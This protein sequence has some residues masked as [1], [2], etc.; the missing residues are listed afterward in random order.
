MV[1]RSAPLD[2]DLVL[3]GAPELVV[4]LSAVTAGATGSSR[5]CAKL[6]Q[7]VRRC[8]YRG[9]YGL[10]TEHALSRFA[11]QTRWVIAC[12][13]GIACVS[14]LQRRIGQSFGPQLVSPHHMLST[15]ISHLELPVWHG[16]GITVA[17]DDPNAPKPHRSLRLRKG[18][19]TIFNDVQVD[20]PTVDASATRTAW[21]SRSIFS[22]ETMLTDGVPTVRCKRQFEMS[23]ADWQTRVE[24]TAEMTGDSRRL[25][26]SG[27]V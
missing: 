5:A 18:S 3:L 14:R 12:N 4:E 23:R 22:D 7:M 20:A 9:A 17:F 27:R 13:Q 10:S 19:Q 1:F 11:V 15:G 2:A 6:R 25:C 8:C 16:E 26:C 24:V 21:R